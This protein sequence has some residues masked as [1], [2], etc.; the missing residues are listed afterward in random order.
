MYTKFFIIKELNKKDWDNYYKDIYFNNL[1]QT[2]EYGE[3]KYRKFFCKPYR[4]IIK[5]KD[6]K[7]IALIQII[8]YK[9]FIFPLIARIN[10][11]PIFFESAKELIRN[12]KLNDDMLHLIELKLKEIGCFVIYLIPDFLFNKNHLK[13]FINN[14]YKLR[15]AETSSSSLVSLSIDQKELMMSFKPKWRNMLRKALK[16]DLKIKCFNGEKKYVDLLLKKYSELKKRNKFKGVNFQ[17]IQ[18]LAI[19]NN[20]NWKFKIFICYKHIDSNVQDELVGILVSIFH[21]NCATYFIGY[22]NQLGRKYNANY[23]M[24]WHSMIEAKK[25][26]CIFYDMGGFN[27]NTPPGIIHFKKGVNGTFYENLPD[28][29]KFLIF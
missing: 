22:T 9:I 28:L 26:K 15:K 25:N 19:Q 6:N 7:P 1:H 11:G 2:W 13:E 3:A 8:I 14:G 18:R 10:K 20:L 16:S 24:L 23:L 12:P 27:R 29:Y 4:F 5:S 21:F 17:F